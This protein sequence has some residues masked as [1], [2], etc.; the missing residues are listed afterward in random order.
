MNFQLD[1]Q[2]NNKENE[3]KSQQLKKEIKALKEEG[4]RLK[5]E[6]TRL[7]Q[8]I[9]KLKAINEDMGSKNSLQEE[10]IRQLEAKLSRLKGELEEIKS[11]P[12]WRKFF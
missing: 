12:F 11:Q 7:S 3:E 8:S 10:I 6:N 5:A 4:Q 9:D 2:K 1:F